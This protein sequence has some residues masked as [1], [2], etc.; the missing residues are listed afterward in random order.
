MKTFIKNH[1]KHIFAFIISVLY[2]LCVY[3]CIDI[4]F[5]TNDDRFM[6]ELLSGAVTGNFET[7]LVYVNYLLSLPLSLLYQIS[8]NVSWFGILLV[9]FH[10]LSCFCIL[11][12]FY[13][14][15]K[16]KTDYFVST[17][18]VGLLFATQLY[19]ITQISYTMTA[20]F[21]AVAGYVCLILQENKK[22]RL[23]YFILLELL[24]FLLRDKA[25]LMIQP[26]GFSVF[27][28]LILTKPQ[29]KLKAKIID[30]LKI[31]IVLIFIVV[32]GFTGNKL[33]YFSEEWQTYNE[34]NQFRTT[35]FDYTEF[36]LNAALEGVQ[37]QPIIKTI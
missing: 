2:I 20:T 28:G 15:A 21:M 1:A 27:L 33:G 4:H 14:K 6:G 16:S 29:M 37:L 10:G 22:S 31:S 36:A 12:S 8:T 13:S 25:M 18:L 26:L 3:F 5:S 34:Y 23:G 7:Q 9:M 19:L 35:L 17:I 32:F 30:L 24:A 11:D